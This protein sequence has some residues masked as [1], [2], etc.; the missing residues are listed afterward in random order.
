MTTT[1]RDPWWKQTRAKISNAVATTITELEQ[2]QGNT[3]ERFVKLAALYDPNGEA[4]MTTALGK[5]GE[6]AIV[7]ENV[8]ASNCDS[9]AAGIAATEV[10]ARFMTDGADW[11]TQ[12]RARMLEWYVE[13]ISVLVDRG[14]KCALAF[15][16]GC[17]VKGIGILHGW[18][19]PHDQLHLDHVYAD[20][21]VVDDRECRGGRKPKQ[22]HIRKEFHK[23]D[24][25]AWY[26]QYEDEIEKAQKTQSTSL[27]WAGTRWEAADELVTWWSYRLPS[28]AKGR[29]GY[30]PGRFTLTID[31]FALVYEKYEDEDFP[32]A[33][34]AWTE[35]EN[36]WYGIGLA[37][38]IA[39]HQRTVNKMNWQVD[40]QLDQWA[41]PTQFVRPV[42]QA[43]VVKSVNRAGAIVPIRGEFPRT[44]I[45]Q[46]VSGETYQRLERVKTSASEESG[47][48]RMQQYGLKP[49]GL[50]SGSALREYKDQS[51]QRHAMQE[52]VF[53]RGNLDACL[54]I[55]SLC[56][57]LGA[58][59]PVIM[60]KTRF[61]SRKVR[62]SEVDMKDVRVQIAAASTLART[63]AG[64]TQ[65]VL[66]LA[67]GGLISQDETRRLLQHPDLERALSIYTAALDNLEHVFDEIRFGAVVVPEPYMN[68]K[69][70]VWR[71]QM[72]YLQWQ[73][74]G[75][76]EEILEVL[77]SFI[78]QAADTLSLQDAA[79]ANMAGPMPGAMPAEA[80]PVAALAPQAMDLRAS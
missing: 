62:W 64:R 77:R 79:N 16:Q 1:A 29:K 35:R 19:D 68:L 22:L 4:A 11:G 67:Q 14:P 63:P 74:D 30:K 10:R 61:G 75:A 71:G 42:D 23:D 44:V 8:V 72:Q 40:R 49:G 18:N 47:S 20:N 41:I 7:T 65:F 80:A 70:C 33:R 31:G 66:E 26:P 27:R 48:N 2:H 73:D 9:I 36:S 54:L 3:F 50:E 51:S 78:V 56:K 28:G 55:V 25:I 32:I 12:N 34:M 39:G 6:Q 60:R 69:M 21:A 53:E 13:G 76:P 38:R 52:K 37:E 17:T 58:K 24:L 57:K 5:K 46:A 43:A 59:A 45:P 15:G